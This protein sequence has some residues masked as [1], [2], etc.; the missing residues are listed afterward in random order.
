[1]ET[2]E[3]AKEA[4]EMMQTILVYMVLHGILALIRDVVGEEVEA[5]NIE[6][7][8]RVRRKIRRFNRIRRKAN[9]RSHGVTV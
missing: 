9:R 4:A 2:D 8:K 5:T 1:M 7:E 3:T 6:Q